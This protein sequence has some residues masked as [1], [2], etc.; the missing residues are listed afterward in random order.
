MSKSN[1]NNHLKYPGL[2]L[3]VHAAEAEERED[4]SFLTPPRLTNAMINTTAQA[5]QRPKKVYQPCSSKSAFY[6]L[7]PK[8]RF[9]ESSPGKVSNDSQASPPLHPSPRRVRCVSSYQQPCDHL[10]WEN[11][12]SYRQVMTATSRRS[13]VACA[14]PAE[15]DKGKDITGVKEA[16][17]RNIN[18]EVLEG[19]K[20]KM[21]F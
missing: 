7:P 10:I 18:G 21:D 11:L 6:A 19:L 8:K 13:G 5:P 4:T 12:D 2:L 3:L 17:T 16:T 1:P 14:P 15:D 9:K 20:R